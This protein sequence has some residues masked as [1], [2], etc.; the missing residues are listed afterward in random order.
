MRTLL[1][2]VI[3]CYRSEQTIE[4]VIDEICTIV[5]EK[6]EEY[7]YEIV[8][9]ND[10]SPDDVYSVLKKLAADDKK[11]KLI[12]FVKNMGKH[13]AV[14][15]GYAV[16]KGDYVVN[17]DDDYQ[18]PTFALWEFL[19]KVESDQCDIAMAHYYVKKE[20]KFKVF[21]SDVN[22]LM[23]NIMLDKPK[24]V[25]YENFSVMKAF[26][27][28][29]MIKYKRP[30]P[31]LEGLMFRVTNRVMNVDV[32]QRERGDDLSTGFTFKK[33]LQLWLNGLTAFSVKP[34]RIASIVGCILASA[35][36]IWGIVIIIQKILGIVY[37]L[38]FST[39][40]AIQLFTSGILMLM[41]GLI[42][43]Y[44]GRIYICINDSPQYIIRETVNLE[45]ED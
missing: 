27:A 1:S 43:E 9:V 5:S 7:D 15:A 34:L 29:E 19:E 36:F 38:G 16:V 32:D 28:E 44:I 26:V 13:A 39:M 17:L 30:Y 25:R 2:F 14:L 21:G 4:R 24:D 18:S 42:G 3:P 12:N 45:K 31:F 11:I 20:S 37:V 35:G 41:V 6:S 10:C 40:V 33:S 22:K 23:T 8:C